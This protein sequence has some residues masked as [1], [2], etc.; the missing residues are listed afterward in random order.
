MAWAL[1]SRLE[2]CEMKTFLSSTHE[3][4]IFTDAVECLYDL[5]L[6]RPPQVRPRLATVESDPR[7]LGNCIARVLPG[8]ARESARLPPVLW[9]SAQIIQEVITISVFIV[10]AVFFL[11][12][13]PA[14]NYLVAFAFL[15]VAA[16][17]AFAFKAPG[18][19][20]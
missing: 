18:P 4:H 17:F 15:G 3:H 6:V 5:R 19:V 7:F 20:T 10:F 8:S 11:K 2:T 13:K 1:Q 9:V 12:E 14:W 16:F